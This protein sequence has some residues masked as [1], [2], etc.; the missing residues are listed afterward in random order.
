MSVTCARIFII[1]R[2]ILNFV[3]KGLKKELD[4]IDLYEVLDDDSSA[5]LGNKLQKFWDDELINSKTKNR[6]PSFL[7]TLIKMFGTKFM[8]IGISMTVIQIILSI[9]ISTMVGL[10]V[11][12][13]ETNTSLDQ[14]PVG[15]YLA[16]GLISLLL[17]RAIIYNSFS[18]SI[19]HI[20]MQIRVATCDLI[21]NKALRL[22]INSLDPTTTGHIINLMSNDVNRFDVSVIYIPFLWLGP[23]ETF[24]SMFFLWQEVGASSVIGVGA[25]LIFIPLQVWLASKT[26]TIRLKT[27]NRTDERVHLMNEIISGLQTI[28]MYTWEPFFDNLTKGLR[29]KEMTQII[30]SSYIK[31]I[32]SSF[33]IFNTRIALF[34]NIF[35]YVLLGNYITASKVFV[36]TTYYGILRSSL[37]LLFPPG[38]SLAAEL[39]VSIKRF[40]NFLLREE[41]DKRPQ[42]QTKTTNM[43]EKSSNGSTVANKNSIDRN[44]TEQLSNTGIVIS[45]ATAK[46]SDT[47]TYYT[48][49]NINLTVKPGRL[50]AIIGPVGA[51]KSSLIQAILQELP[52]TAGDISV[53]GVV[54]YASQEPWLFAGSVRQNILFGSPMDKDRYKR[55]IQVCALKTDLEQL[56]YGDRTIVGERGVSLSGGQR[57]RI[58]LARAMY[59][60]ADIYLLDDPL[61]AVDTRVG[62]HLYEKCIKSY[63]KEKT[64]ILVTHQIQYLIDVDQIVLMEN[65]KVVTEGSY[66]E[67]QAS[68]LDFTKLLES[69]TETAVLPDNERKIDKSSNNNMARSISYIRQESILSVASSIEETKFN[70]IITEPVEIAETRSSGNISFKVYM[71][72]IFAGGHSCKV[73]SLILV[74][75]FTQLFASG[76][77]YW[78]TYWVNL[79]EHVFG[80]TKPNSYS[81]STTDDSSVE[82]MPLIVSRETCVIVFAALTILI[83]I[84]TLAETVLLVSVC[85]TASTNL[86]NQMFTAITRSTMNFLNKNPSGRILNR[87][88]KDIGLIDEILP[89]ILVDVIQMGLMVIGM[90]VVVGIVNPYLTIPI[91]IVMMVFFK[92]R[93]VYMT[94]TR[95]IKR[96]EGVTR[97]PMYTHVNA[98]ILGLTTVRSFEVEQILS[99]EFAIHQD[100]HSSAWYL[101]ISLSRAFGFWL[102]IICLLFISAVTFYFI[103][104][105]NGTYGGNV[106][107]AITQSIGLTSLFQWVTRQSAELENQMTSVERVLEYSNVPQESALESP[108]DKKPSKIWPHEGQIIFKTFYLRYDQDAPFILNNLNFNIAPAEKVGIVGRTGAGK[109]SLIAALFRL[110]VNEGNI[111]IDGVEIHEL[112]L[113]DLR[114]KISIIPQEPV[115][116]SGTMR[117]NL[118]PFDEYPDHV[119]WKALDEVELK[120]VVEDLPNGL[121]SKMSEGGSNFSV[122]QR[123]LVCLARAIIRNNKILVLDEATAN[124]DPQTDSLIQKT[125]RNKFSKCTV[126]TIAHRLNTVMDSDKILVIDAGSVVEF[127]HP[128]NLL[129]NKDGFLYQMVEQTGQGNAESLYSLAYESYN[130]VQNMSSEHPLTSINEDGN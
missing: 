13:F 38:I 120:Y 102:D 71:S 31:R 12:H 3:K 108:P 88:S 61:S 86:H 95:N 29:K 104:I 52:L 97:S 79:E 93:Y 28:K 44:D 1:L 119:L 126:L 112:G 54:S 111:I 2:W 98:S 122:G 11:N 69:S 85:T 67:L 25:L 73:I 18:M 115:L 117:N 68:G 45:N 24:A 30:E 36:I 27:A 19:A 72:Y 107:L 75:I 80:A 65:A 127:D 46:W 116:F 129:K 91:I 89:N 10:I 39:L 22:K 60:K 33:F 76:G 87:F 48:L 57:A 51:G 32:L 8:L 55:V 16:I 40:E 113:H 62:K 83:I 99:K 23:L 130:K 100:L 125:I 15:V 5:L 77:D 50:V 128:Y 21:Y 26:S 94:T 17:I 37:S 96:L 70:D 47:Q 63:L 81:N 66:K 101:F 34:V 106:G 78:I 7:K 14:N 118:D 114:S 74:C 84:A 9:S 43:L 121:N 124:V 82:L 49:D 4:L 58:N 41:K 59:K 103:F 56:T 42:S 90:F 53:R 105:D 20:S 123:Q 6:K 110:A 35:S 64:C 92:M 109:S